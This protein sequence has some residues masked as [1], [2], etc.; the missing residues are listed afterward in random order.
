MK[1]LIVGANGLLGSGAVAALSADNEI[2]QASRSGDVSVDLTDPNSIAAMYEKVGKVDA[3]IAATG[4][5]PCW[6][7]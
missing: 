6:Y 5:V 7:Q 4:V 1:I 2:I 3:V